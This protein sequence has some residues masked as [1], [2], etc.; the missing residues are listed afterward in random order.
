ML[1]SKFKKK[2]FEEL[3]A[4]YPQHE[5]QSFFDLLSE[6]KLGLRRV[7]IALNTTLKLN[8][9]DLI[10]FKNALELLEKK[11]PIQYIIGETPFYGF[12]ILVNEH[13]LIPR[14]ET[15]ELVDWIVADFK[16]RTDLKILDIGTGSA[17]IPIALNKHLDIQECEAIDI[18]SKALETAAIN[19][20]LNKVFV[21]FINANIL[22]V[23]QLHSSFDLI[24]SNP[25]YVLEAEKEQMD[26]NVLKFEP[27]QALFVPNKDPLLFYKKI[28]KLAL[29][30]LRPEGKLYFE[31]NQ[32]YG[33]EICLLLEE[34]GFVN[35]VLKKDIYGVDRMVR[36]ELL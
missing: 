6:K 32:K 16:K 18:S 5:I 9:Q 4:Q 28:A 15:E 23:K 31:I 36:A 34:Y 29:S 14:P 7:D 19:A 10:Y 30:G 35:C 2:F 21:N 25:P 3:K 24:V 20:K 11:T 12:T 22:N 1:L 33:S 13:V 17:C 8:T 27:E 26:D